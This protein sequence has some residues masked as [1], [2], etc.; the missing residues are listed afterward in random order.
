MI[1]FKG[2]GNSVEDEAHSYWPSP[3]LKE[4][5]PYWRP[6]EKE[7][8]LRAGTTINTKAVSTGLIDVSD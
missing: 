7:Q 6:V 4:K 2:E 5:H 8:W 1:Y 3:T